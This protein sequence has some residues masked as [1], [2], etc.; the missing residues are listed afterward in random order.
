MASD[1]LFLRELSLA[2]RSAVQARN[3]LAAIAAQS[4]RLGEALPE[5]VAAF[6]IMMQRL[7]DGDEKG[8]TKIYL[9]SLI[10]RIKV[11]ANE[12][13]I[14]GDQEVLGHLIARR[15]SEI[16]AEGKEN[17]SEVHTSMLEWWI[18]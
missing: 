10:S 14:L 9:R 5:Q 6:A 15:D 18:R 8:R 12:I 1:P 3:E 4:T 16:E 7:L 11:G 2:R 17:S 13:R